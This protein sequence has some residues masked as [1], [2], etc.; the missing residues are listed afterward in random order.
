MTQARKTTDEK[1]VVPV[2]KEPRAVDRETPS[3]VVA[4]FNEMERMMEQMFGN[5]FHRD[6]ARP[7]RLGL[8]SWSDLSAPFDAAL[9]KVD[10]LDRDD[11]IL[12]RA[13]LPGVDKKDLDVTISGN[14]VTIKGV[15]SHEEKKEEGNYF[16]QEISKG[17][18]CRTLGLPGDV[19]TSDPEATFED[20]VLKITLNK[21]E[22]AKRRSVKIH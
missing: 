3:R 9:P 6:W 5:F 15:T 12:L 11:D 14:S 18:F 8:P 22:E 4:P 7:L 21:V 19:D 20:G 17:S 13:E 1:K 2:R 10:I 16:R